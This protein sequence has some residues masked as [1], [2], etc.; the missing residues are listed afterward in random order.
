MKNAL[1]ALSL[2]CVFAAAPAFSGTPENDIEHNARKQQELVAFNPHYQELRAERV[3]L[4]RALAQRVEQREA[5][6][7][8]TACSHQI[9]FELKLLTYFSADF[10]A[11]D[12]RIRDLQTVLAHPEREASAEKQNPEDGSWGACY[13]G[14]H[15][16]LYASY[17]HCDDPIAKP[18]RFLDRVNSPEKLTAY[19]TAIATSDVARTGVDHAFELN[20]SLSE[21]MRLIL[22]D[23]PKGYGW[24]PRLKQTMMDLL[25]G[26]LR[27]PDTGW[28]GERYV[29]DGRV[30]FVDDLSM[31]FHTVSYLDG[32]VPD[33][34]KIIDTALALKTVNT[35]AGWL[36][37]GAYWNHNNM[38]VAVL[39]RFGWAEASAAQR[40]AMRAEIEKMLRWSLAE[41]LQRD[42]SFKPL[43]ADG[44]LEEA[45]Y[46]GAAFLARIGYFDR[47]RRFWTD[48]DFADSEAIRKSIIDN[49][50]KHI[51]SG[52]AGSFYYKSILE[53]L[54]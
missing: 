48:A 53:E 52:G 49:I 11:I 31:T 46:F 19:L 7:E 28:W 10:D 26:Q 12:G 54:Q 22:R 40:Q 36:W 30:K 37:D 35:P 17:D 45:N 33:L 43:L 51:K 50:G 44:S 14:W 34:P 32:K 3:A 42:G 5:A 25:V 6:R 20:E 9:L 18:F 38:D 23:R 29:R 1:A 47:A 15:L 41:S 2:S 24:H 21:L 8:S 4:L 16:K 39:F 13:E 27:N